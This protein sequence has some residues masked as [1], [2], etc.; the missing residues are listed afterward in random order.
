[1]ETLWFILLVIGAYLLGSVPAAYL[2]IK[3]SRGTDIRKVGTGKVGAANVLN[4]GPKWLA[5]PVAI[6]DIGKGAL[7]VGIAKLIN[8]PIAYQ[9]TIGI[10]AIAGHDWPVYLGF[11]SGGRGVF[12]SLGVIAMLSW[13]I[14]LIALIFPYLLAPI[15]QVAFGVFVFF[16][17]LPLLS[18]FLAGPL[19]VR[20]EDKVAITCGFTVLSGIALLKRTVARRTGLS[21]NMPLGKVVFYRLLFDR[22]IADRKLWNSLGVSSQ[23]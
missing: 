23:G 12:V 21:K 18:Y 5:I 15:K 6:F 10:F 13:K 16:V 8:L 14:G 20:V 19:L 17:A 3:W 9:V 7:V 4:A 22:D 2:A 11:K 1:M